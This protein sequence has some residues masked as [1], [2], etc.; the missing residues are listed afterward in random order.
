MLQEIVPSSPKL[1][2]QPI[3]VAGQKEPGMFDSFEAYPWFL[4]VHPSESPAQLLADLSAS[5]AAFGVASGRPW[6]PSPDVP[7]GRI[8]GLGRTEGTGGDSGRTGAAGKAPCPPEAVS[9]F[10]VETTDGSLP[11][12]VR[13]G[14]QEDHI[15]RLLFR[16]LI[17][18][19]PKKIGRIL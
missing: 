8:A 1:P 4:K 3:V 16:E 19:L 15:F 9:I 17:Q 18:K 11:C 13:V 2:V 7:K 5:S 14:A 6:R 12:P 10:H